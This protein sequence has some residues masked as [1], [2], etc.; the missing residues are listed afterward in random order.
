[1]KVEVHFMCVNKLHTNTTTTRE[2][3]ETYT[4]VSVS[5]LCPTPQV[6]KNERKG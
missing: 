3:P 2:I 1:M 6:P 5:V 4:C